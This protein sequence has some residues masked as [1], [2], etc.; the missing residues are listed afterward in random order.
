MEELGYGYGYVLYRCR[1]S[2]PG[3]VEQVTLLDC[4]DRATVYVNGRFVLALSGNEVD[5]PFALE[6]PLS[7]NLI[8]VLVENQG[9]VNFGPRM[10]SQR[11]G[12]CG[13]IALEGHFH[14]PVESWPL[15]LET[16][17]GIDWAVRDEADGETLAGQATFSRFVFEYRAEP[18]QW[19]DS[20]LRLDNWGKGVAWLNGRNLGRY[21][22]AGPQRALY[23]PGPFLV[24]GQNE[25]VVFETDGRA[26][27]TVELTSRPDL[28]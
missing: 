21:F 10:N 24:D 26:A 9:R 18:G 4:H 6:L 7:S 22:S 1:R 17:A 27:K 23:V 2:G 5:K 15:P 3:K 14:S 16:V 13:A 12:I 19:H 11:K 8:E 28:G 20:F 25:L